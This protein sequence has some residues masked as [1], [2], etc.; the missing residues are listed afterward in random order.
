MSKGKITNKLIP[1]FEKSLFEG[2]KKVIGDLTE[3][4]IDKSY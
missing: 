3:I 1:N 2:A 4:G